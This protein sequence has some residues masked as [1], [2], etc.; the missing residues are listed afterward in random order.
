MVNNCRQR[1]SL[2]STLVA[3]KG[4]TLSKQSVNPYKPGVLFVGQWQ[5]VQNQ[6]RRRKARRLIRF[7]TVCKQKFL[8]KVDNN[9]K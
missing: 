8:L 5:T 4:N 2:V 9:V 6:I 3:I 7:S 1:V